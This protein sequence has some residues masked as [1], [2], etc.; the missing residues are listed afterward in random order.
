MEQEQKEIKAEVE[1]VEKKWVCPKCKAEDSVR[2]YVGLDEGHYIIDGENIDGNNI[3]E[4]IDQYHAD[5]GYDEFS[6]VVDYDVRC[7]ECNTILDVERDYR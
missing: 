1:E 7:K 4:L 2:V 6:G 3:D 5:K